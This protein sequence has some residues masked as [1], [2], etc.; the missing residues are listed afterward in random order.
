MLS[1]V[2]HEKSFIT[3]GLGFRD[4]LNTLTA[5]TAEDLLMD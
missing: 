2:V 3:S 1:R 4:I 5:D